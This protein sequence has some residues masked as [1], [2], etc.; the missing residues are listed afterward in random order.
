MKDLL[1]LV[2]A[3]A[4]CHIR[5]LHHLSALI[6]VVLL[7]GCS[8][9]PADLGQGEVNELVAARGQTVEEN[10][11]NL[12]E[13]LTS[14]PLS[15]ESAVRIALINNP[16]LQA[17][18]ASLGFGAADV[19]E[20]GRI[21]NP[22]LSG[23]FLDTDAAG[24]QD[25]VTYGLAV[26]FTDLITLPARKR[27]S[28]GVF[29]AMKQQVGSDVLGVAAAAEKAYYEYVGAQ[30]V[31]ALRDQIANAGKLSARLAQ[32]FFD[33]GNLAPRELAMERAAASEAK[34]NALEAANAAFAARTELA[35]V[36]GLSVGAPWIAPAALRLPVTDE[37][38]LDTLL[39]LA[40]ESR[41]DL[42]AART[43]ADVLADRLGVVNW[44]RWLGELDVGAERERDTDGSR[45]TGPTVDWEVPIFDQHRDAVLRADAELQIAI[46]E[47][48]RA[49][50][51]VDNS[52]RLASAALENMRARIKEYQTTL[53]P[54][55]VEAVAR[56]Q[57][58]VN[59]MLIGIFE[60]ITLKQD[61]YDAYQ[62]YLEA[63]GD[64]WVA[65][66]DLALAVGASLP[67]TASIGSELIDVDQFV[68]PQSGEHNH[69]GAQ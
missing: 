37:D 32:R 38:D 33:A 18:Y 30:Q 49:T 46:S 65:R 67:S 26:S 52:V 17:S 14:A 29:A 1:S 60:L 61:E 11:G 44:T 51:D 54:Q 57:E 50:I 40:M 63:I 12:L 43:N 4:I 48:R 19:Y 36:L 23:A 8:S 56:A 62:G 47:V 22:T 45:L 7:G 41:L 5:R 34:L 31:A 3:V 15:A 69:G 27:L 21:R 2:A 20:A 16:E 53:I 13:T 66:A 28:L 68:Q 58:E 6:A 39:A 24:A 9:F 55:R 59:F 35:D 25:Q 64:Y 10:T 42:A